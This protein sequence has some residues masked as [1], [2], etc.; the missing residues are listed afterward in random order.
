MLSGFTPP[1]NYQSPRVFCSVPQQTMSTLQPRP[2]DSSGDTRHDKHS[3]RCTHNPRFI[4]KQ[5]NFPRIS[6]LFHTSHK[7]SFGQKKQ[8]Q[9]FRALIPP[10]NDLT[11]LNWVWLRGCHSTSS[12]Q[13]SMSLLAAALTGG[14]INVVYSLKTTYRLAVQRVY[15]YFLPG[16]LLSLAGF[17]LGSFYEYLLFIRD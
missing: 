9:N 12:G 10:T 17:C 4:K 5:V 8:D 11:Q 13:S 7:F 14:Y 2:T 15:Y 6:T 16:P 1:D 3:Y